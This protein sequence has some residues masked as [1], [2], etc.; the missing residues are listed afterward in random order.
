MRQMQHY[1]EGQPPKGLG[2][3]GE[4]LPYGCDNIQQWN[5]IEDRRRGGKF[6]PNGWSHY[7]SGYRS[8]GDER[9]YVVMLTEDGRDAVLVSRNYDII[10]TIPKAKAFDFLLKCRVHGMWLE[11]YSL[12]RRIEGYDRHK[13][14]AAFW[15]D[16]WGD[17]FRSLHLKL[18]QFCPDNRS[19]SGVQQ[20]VYDQLRLY[21]QVKGKVKWVPTTTSQGWR[22]SS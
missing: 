8:G 20:T 2:Y 4:L 10:G 14:M 3:E 13:K 6:D 15:L 1:K 17:F 21:A 16:D 18:Y 12:S 7:P 22:I 9:V 19:F 5:W 11:G